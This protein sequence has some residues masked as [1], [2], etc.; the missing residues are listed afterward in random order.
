MGTR[1]E[2]LAKQFEAKVQEALAVV[3][4]LSDVD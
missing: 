1:G 4:Q 3:E 2:T